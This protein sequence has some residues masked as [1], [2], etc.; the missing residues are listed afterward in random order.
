MKIMMLPIEMIAWF[1]ENG[2]LTPIRLKKESAVFKVEQVC[3]MSDEKLVRN[4]MILYRCQ[5]VFNEILP[6]GAFWRSGFSNVKFY[7]LRRWMINSKLM[8]TIARRVI[9]PP[10]S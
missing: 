4:W 6:T 1:K 9:I 2:W 7:K 10:T 3:Q 5:S 8:I